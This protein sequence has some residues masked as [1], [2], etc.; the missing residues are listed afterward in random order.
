MSI[1]DPPLLINALD[2]NDQSNI[3]GH[4]SLDPSNVSSSYHNVS[5]YEFP[6]INPP[7][8]A[9][10]A[11]AASLYP[12]ATDPMQYAISSH[13]NTW[14]TML[15][16][17]ASSGS[18]NNTIHPGAMSFD[19]IP[20]PP[21]LSHSTNSSPSDLTSIPDF[22]SYPTFSIPH[23][24]VHPNDPIIHSPYDE[25]PGSFSPFATHMSFPEESDSA[26]P[27][28]VGTLSPATV[29]PQLYFPDASHSGGHATMQQQQHTTPQQ[30]QLL[31][32]PQQQRRKSMTSV[33]SQS[34]NSDSKIAKHDPLAGE[35]IR[36][37]LGEHKWKIFSSRL[38]E[39]RASKHKLKLS[40]SS[41][42]SITAEDDVNGHSSAEGIAAVS[43]G[44][45][46]K[47]SS[48]ASVL[49]F[50]VKVEVVKAVLRTY[51]P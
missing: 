26:L 43:T 7:P 16:D 13:S 20:G 28:V 37:Q 10:A 49:D 36:A 6:A 29:R 50:L 45:I 38:A 17:Y 25:R 33:T 8:A 41:I 21:P 5:H 19:P 22:D 15:S 48:G 3:P 47:S 9:G 44:C 12:L 14:H 51:V 40:S 32:Q 11:G 24:T 42:R 23:T 18:T 30:P 46:G 2:I 39:Q 1:L 4:S 34:D 27:E 35:F 31:P